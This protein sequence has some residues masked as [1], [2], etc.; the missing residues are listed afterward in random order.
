MGTPEPL[1]DRPEGVDAAAPRWQVRL[2]GAVQLRRPDGTVCLD[3]LPTRAEAA[4]LARLALAPDAEWSRDAVVESLWPGAAPAVGRNRLR[5]ALASL[6]RRLV[7]AGAP[8]TLVT[9]DRLHLRAGGLGCD[10]WELERAA[11]AGDAAGLARLPA[12]EFMPGHDDEWAEQWRRRLRPLT[13][14]AQRADAGPA[15]PRSDVPQAPLPPAA[16]R[17]GYLTRLFGA[18]PALAALEDCLRR[19]RLVTLL[20]PGG[21]GKT[22]LAVELLARLDAAGT[23]A[24]A[25]TSAAARA[26]G[27][28]LPGLPALFVSLVG[29]C[30]RPSVVAAVARGLGLASDDEAA[31]A[32]ALAA[33]ARP[34]EAPRSPGPAAARRLVLVLDNAEQLA[35]GAVGWVGELLQAVPTLQVLVTSRRPLGLDGEWRVAAEP[36]PAR[37]AD[38]GAGPAVALYLDRVAA[39]LGAPGRQPAGQ[40][41]GR[42]AAADPADPADPLAPRDAADRDDLRDTAAIQALVQRLGGLPLAIELAATRA[43]SHGPRQML[44]LLDTAR[45]APPQVDP[46]ALPDAPHLELLRRPTAAP[47][48]RHGSMAAVLEWSWALLDPPS[49]RLLAALAQIDG[50]AG[51]LSVAAML[52]EPPGRTAA[53]LDALAAHGLVRVL[54][55]ARS[56][57]FDLPEPV[58]EFARLRTPPA[59]ALRLRGALRRHLV[60]W[61]GRQAAGALAEVAAELPAVL[62]ACVRATPDGVPEDGLRLALALRPY[63]DSDGRPTRLRQ[64]LEDALAAAAQARLH[65]PQAVPVVDAGLACDAHE[66]LAHL[67]FDAG[68]PDLARRHADAAVAAAEHAGPDGRCDPGRRARALARR[69]WTA[70]AA[71]RVPHRPG[72]QEQAWLAELDEALALAQACGDTEAE[73]R[74]WQQL[75][76]RAAEVRHDLHQAE[77]CMARAQA[78]WQ[79][80]GDT[81]KAQARLRNRA[82]LW[83]RMGRAAQALPVLRDSERLARA[84]GDWLG[85]IDA[86]LSLASAERQLRHWDE[87]L[88]ADRAALELAWERWHRHALGHALWGP[89]VALAR[90]RRPRPAARVTAFAAAF[91]RS[92]FGVLGEHDLQAAR[93]VRRLVCVQ[94]GPAATEAEWACGEA[95]SLPQAVALLQPS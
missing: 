28:P 50:P 6:R 23:A 85:R 53:R 2:L 83:V 9:A 47:H 4:L 35:A 43:A 60:A 79:L 91:W 20:G 1:R 94:L 49:Q 36:M 16:T 69:A 32:P 55:Q 76:A 12:G 89:G 51:C 88:A 44:A 68:F 54:A 72:T 93:R 59:L 90:L 57:R 40:R 42:A 19:Q 3:R 74:V 46:E 75:G 29:C 61:A 58:R 10:V 84:S 65:D 27:N 66:L 37:A 77:A 5:Q 70:L 22:R 62:S 34:G 87:A 48:D 17:P 15:P 56:P 8:A 38:G 30:E 18:E 26:R 14:D 13:G 81:R 92:Q 64:A 41:A 73:A 21:A 24:A 82:Q 95:L 33:L 67:Q 25:A 31:V 7:Q 63:W 39:V 80:R 45:A 52:E 11:Q 78:L 71:A 86:L